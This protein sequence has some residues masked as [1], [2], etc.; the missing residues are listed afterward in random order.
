MYKGLELSSLTRSQ[1]I[2]DNSHK[3]SSYTAE[4]LMHIAVNGLK[5]QID[6]LS[7]A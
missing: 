6:W 7:K 4:L 5:G 1:T 2:G 3:Y